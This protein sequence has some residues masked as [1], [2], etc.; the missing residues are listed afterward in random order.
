MET[1]TP[2]QL[3]HILG[4]M[5]RFALR[6]PS[7]ARALV[8]ENTQLALALEHAEFLVGLVET[9]SLPTDPEV[10]ERAKTVREK[11][12]QGGAPA[13]PMKPC[14]QPQPPSGPPP[15]GL[16][17]PGLQA[18]GVPPVSFGPSAITGMPG[19]QRVAPYPG[20]PQQLVP[21]GVPLGGASQPQSEESRQALL[22][23]L[24]KLSPQQIDL[25][26]AHAKV[27]LLEY[28]QTL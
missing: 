14:T 23:R 25:L 13:V 16:M 15:L 10:K 20:P 5:Q 21:P 17:M 26:P 2:P 3:F 4:E 11:V 18:P 19:S 12:W 22:Q 24:V 1:L 6:A 8:G 9:P 7:I 28:L 27:Q